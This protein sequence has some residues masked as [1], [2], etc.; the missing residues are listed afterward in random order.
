ME[1]CVYPVDLDMTEIDKKLKTVLG[2]HAN[3]LRELAKG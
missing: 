2:R 1:I 3:F